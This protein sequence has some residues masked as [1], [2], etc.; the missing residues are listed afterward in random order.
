MVRFSDG[1]QVYVDGCSGKVLGAQPRYGGLYGTVE[2]LHKFRFAPAVAAKPIIGTTSL[3]LAS[4]L[5]VGG[6]FAWWPRRRSAW[7]HALTLDRKLTGR[8]FTLRLHTTVGVY[9][10]AIIFVVALTA[11]PLSLGWAKNALFVATRTSDMTQ[12]APPPP[13]AAKKLERRIS[14]QAAFS[15]ARA[16]VGGPLL[17]AS[18]H[19]PAKGEPIEIGI[20]QRSAPHG[21]ARNYVYIDPRSAKVI[22]FRP[23][24]TLNAGSKLYYW[25]LALHTGHVGGVAVQLLMLAGMLG[26]VTLGYAGID[27]FL[28]KT[29]RRRKSAATETNRFTNP[30]LLER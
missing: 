9:A 22:A 8:A 16:L 2:S 29:F 28:R 17:W 26:V 11:V 15:E 4:V 19:Y 6:V 24:A 10:S 30:P 5:V 13:I 1:D 18:V 3:L 14:M 23:Y 7:R 20:V 21:D 12:D 27:S 25:A